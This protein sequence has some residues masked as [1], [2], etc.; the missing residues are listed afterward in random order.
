MKFHIWGFSVPFLR[1]NQETQTSFNTFAANM[2]F[3]P[4]IQSIRDDFHNFDYVKEK[5]IFCTNQTFLAGVYVGG[6]RVLKDNT[7]TRR[8]KKLL[9]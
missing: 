8:Y 2:Y 3:P 5:C 1:G 6:E 9:S 4:K 7:P